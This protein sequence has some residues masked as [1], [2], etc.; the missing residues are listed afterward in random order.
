M[1]INKIVVFRKVCFISRTQELGDNKHFQLEEITVRS[2]AIHLPDPRTSFL[3]R[4]QS[5]YDYY[6]KPD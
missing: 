3:S 2:R 6:H 1:R 5:G 4:R